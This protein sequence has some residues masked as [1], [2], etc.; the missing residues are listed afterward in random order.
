LN[1]K[2]SF[3]FGFWLEWEWDETRCINPIH[4]SNLQQ[5]GISNSTK[6]NGCYEILVAWGK[7]ISISIFSHS[8]EREREYE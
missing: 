7:V 1:L 6:S 3:F 2:P 4:Q 8:S 5:L